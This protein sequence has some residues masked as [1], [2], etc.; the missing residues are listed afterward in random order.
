[1]KK[2]IFI[3]LLS[4]TL[5]GFNDA[6]AQ[7]GRNNNSDF[8]VP[9]PVVAPPLN[10][11]FGFNMVVPAMPPINVPA[12]ITPSLITASYLPQ[13]PSA[14]LMPRAPESNM[15]QSLQGEVTKSNY[16]KTIKLPPL[17]SIPPNP[18]VRLAL[19]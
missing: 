18:Q 1:M 8:K 16:P 6:M 12:V 9:L 5:I 14:P 19:Y 10:P 13:I 17:A 7:N 4:F 15:L 3:F 2:L 11:D